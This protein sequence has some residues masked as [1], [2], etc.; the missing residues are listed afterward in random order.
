MQNLINAGSLHKNLCYEKK[1]SDQ[2]LQIFFA[3]QIF[4][5]V[6]QRFC[7]SFLVAHGIVTLKFKVIVSMGWLPVDTKRRKFVR[8][9]RNRHDWPKEQWIPEIFYRKYKSQFQLISKQVI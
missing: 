1:K 7:N 8:G 2:R 6:K 4:C 9:T 3:T 5:T